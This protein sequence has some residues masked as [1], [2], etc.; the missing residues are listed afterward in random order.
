MFLCKRCHDP[1]CIH[2]SGSHGRCEGCGKTADCVDCLAYKR[3][4]KR[5]PKLDALFDKR[6][7]PVRVTNKNAQAYRSAFTDAEWKRQPAKLRERIERALVRRATTSEA[8]KMLL[9]DFGDE[10]HTECNHGIGHCQYSLMFQ[11][12]FKAERQRQYEAK[13]NAV[14]DGCG[15]KGGDIKSCGKDANGDPD[16]PDLCFICRRTYARGGE[17]KRKPTATLGE[18]DKVAR[19]VEARLNKRSEKLL[20]ET[21]KALQLG[22]ALV[23]AAWNCSRRPDDPK[24]QKMTDY[25]KGPTEAALRNAAD[26]VEKELR[27]LKRIEE[28]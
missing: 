28:E 10:D 6:G 25:D 2:F 24:F 7:Y 26:K 4:P 16:A 23:N 5:K 3:K 1:E 9:A 11:T 12:L 14:C 17:P 20:K 19:R 8:E 22:I 21:S 13:Q 18:L 27:L 15:R